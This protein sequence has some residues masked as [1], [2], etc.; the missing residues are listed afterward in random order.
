MSYQRE[1]WRCVDL[2]AH[3][4]QR[5]KLHWY[6]NVGERTK[7]GYVPL[8]VD[9]HTYSIYA[10]VSVHTAFP[11]H[12]HSPTQLITAILLGVFEMFL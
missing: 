10:R 11:A 12:S 6:V 4:H 3:S 2:N 9:V 5:H 1:T 7:D 8:H